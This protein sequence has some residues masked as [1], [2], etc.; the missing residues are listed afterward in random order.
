M[1]QKKIEKF[2]NEKNVKVTKRKNAF[3]GYAST[4]IVE[5]SNSFNPELQ[6]K[7]VESAIKSKPIELSTE[8]KYFEFVTKLVSLLIKIERKWR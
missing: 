7:D 2:F 6:L 8:L 3:K 1:T 4:Y 5:T